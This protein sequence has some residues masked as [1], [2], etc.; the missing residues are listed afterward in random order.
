MNPKN[1]KSSMNST[2]PIIDKI[3]AEVSI[4]HPSDQIAF[5]KKV[6]STFDD[7]TKERWFNTVAYL[8]YPETRWARV[9]AWIEKRFEKNLNQ[10]PR[11]VAS[12]AMFYMK[13]NTKMSPLMIKLSQK[14][15]NRVRKRN[16]KL[17]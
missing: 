5:L 17:L 9:E 8:S 15:K 14:V 13:I 11:K 6:F 1:S 7:K 12:M 2:N 3:A 4:M 10:T 16:K